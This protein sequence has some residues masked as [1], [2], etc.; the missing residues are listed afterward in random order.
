MPTS[1]VNEW[2]RISGCPIQ[3][4]NL[5]YS[6]II[7]NSWFIYQRYP[8]KNEQYWTQQGITFWG[9]AFRSNDQYVRSSRQPFFSTQHMVSEVRYCNNIRSVVVHGKVSLLGQYVPLAMLLLSDSQFIFLSNLFISS[10]Y[11]KLQNKND[12]KTILNLPPMD[13]ISYICQFQVSSNRLQLRKM[14]LVK[15][16]L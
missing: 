6:K 1:T 4:Q 7:I 13:V 3:L 12:R 11:H 14:F 16:K 2:H 8:Y 9:A 5:S 10:V 15:K